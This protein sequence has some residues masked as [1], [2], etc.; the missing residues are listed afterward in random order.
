MLRESADNN[1]EPRFTRVR[2]LRLFV[3]AGD[4]VQSMS[5]DHR[6]P[7]LLKMVDRLSRTGGKRHGAPNAGLR[8][9]LEWADYRADSVVMVVVQLKI[10]I[11]TEEQAC[12]NSTEMVV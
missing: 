11:R 7:T 4:H 3:A 10:K 6:I 2:M 12:L 5:G 9:L 8:V 1:T